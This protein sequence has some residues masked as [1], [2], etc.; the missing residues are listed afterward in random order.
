MYTLQL[1]VQ[2]LEVIV[3]QNWLYQNIGHLHKAIFLHLCIDLSR[4]DF[5]S[6][7]RISW[8]YLPIVNYQLICMQTINN[9]NQSNYYFAKINQ[10]KTNYPIFSMIN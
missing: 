10:T 6:L 2:N 1:Y 5:S 9:V 7:L 4:N 3:F 8:S